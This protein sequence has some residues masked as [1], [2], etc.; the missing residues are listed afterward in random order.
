VWWLAGCGGADEQ[1]PLALA[2]LQV[3]VPAQ[4]VELE[5][6]ELDRLRVAVQAAAPDQVHVLSAARHPAGA[7]VAVVQLQRSLAAT[8]GRHGAT[9]DAALAGVEAEL[10]AGLPADGLTAEARAGGRDLCWTAGAVHTCALAQVTPSQELLVRSVTCSAVNAGLCARVLAS[11]HLEPVEVL[12]LDTPLPVAGL[13]GVKANRVWGVELGST[14]SEFHA[15]CRA[16]GRTIDGYDWAVEPAVVKD[17]VESGRAARC[18]DLPTPPVGL[19]RVTAASAVFA[20]D[21]L[22][23]LTVYLDTPPEVVE[24]VV[25]SA[26]P[27]AIAGEDQVLHV[28]D[29]E[30]AD[31]SLLSVTVLGSSAPGARSSL[32]FLTRRGADL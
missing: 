30:A 22:V 31:Y 20:A 29:A 14:R 23:G 4:F 21:R 24:A 28:V 3:D 15:A 26:Y 18:S 10:R 12:P 5:A 25:A 2:G 16:A 9:V 8:A 6:A 11:R 27:Q 1:R 19:G 17:W 13:P 7:D 32:T